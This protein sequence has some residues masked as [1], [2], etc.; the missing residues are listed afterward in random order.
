[1]KRKQ[2]KRC[3]KLACKSYESLLRI[4]NNSYYRS[5]KLTIPLITKHLRS[6]KL[7]LY[8]AHLVDPHDD[9]GVAL[10]RYVKRLDTLQ[11]A[12]QSVLDYEPS[13]VVRDRKD[14]VRDVTNGLIHLIDK[15]G[16]ELTRSDEL[17]FVV[18]DV[19]I[20]DI[21]LGDYSVTVPIKNSFAPTRISSLA[22]DT[23]TYPHPHIGLT[24]HPCLGN[25][26][27]SFFSAFQAGD[28]VG[29]L[30]IS[31][32]Y[33]RSY[34]YTSA[35]A[36]VEFLYGIPC[37]VCGAIRIEDELST[38]TSCNI[39][40]CCG[41]QCTDCGDD[42]CGNCDLPTAD[43]CSISLCSNCSNS[44]VTC[45]NVICS[46]HTNSCSN[47]CNAVC[48]DCLLTCHSCDEKICKNHS[49]DC[50]CEK[51]ICDDCQATCDECESSICPNNSPTCDSCTD[52]RNCEIETNK[53]VA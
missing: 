7:A 34:D 9:G 22:E 23:R 31:D 28:V 30:D 39:V 53:E 3:Y 41:A 45:E 8:R 50:L 17:Y 19:S 6:T 38:C 18:E 20:N 44:C 43:C 2:I 14:W 11:I 48:D 29:I 47:C 25:A 10:N 52:A 51:T 15:E 24:D 21:H 49:S 37:D 42:F 1:M 33:L 5:L 27:E 12:T 4:V 40:S 35:Y 32:S 36:P 13:T 16:F 46:K 26:K